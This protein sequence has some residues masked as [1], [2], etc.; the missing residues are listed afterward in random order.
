MQIIDLGTLDY[1]SAWAVQE[2]AHAE[3]V[4]GASERIFLVEHPPVITYGRRP[5]GA[6]HI[7]AAADQLERMNI[8]VV[9]SDRGG[10]ATLHAPGQL[11]AYPIIN[12]ARHRLS[13]GGYVHRLEDAVIDALATFEVHGIKDPSAPGVWIDQTGGSLSK[14]CALGVRIR[15][16]VTLHGLALNV[17]NDLA[18]FDL[19]VPC[20][21][22]GRGVTSLK[23]L[24]GNDCPTLETVKA[25]LADAL[26]AAITVI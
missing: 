22:A 23:K 18:L 13:V 5:D 14:I 7:L 9:Q 8:K 19:I 24:L 20:G 16:G 10:D 17:I 15:R 11:V 12:L 26:V 6:K 1:Q 25:A 21:L 2:A 3:V 4:G